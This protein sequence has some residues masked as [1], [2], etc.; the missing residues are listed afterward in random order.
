MQHTPASNEKGGGPQR[1]PLFLLWPGL[2]SCCGRVSVRVVTGSLFVLWLWFCGWLSVARALWLV[3]CGRGF[4]TGVLWLGFC[5]WGFVA[6]SLWLD[7]VPQGSTD[8][9]R[10]GLTPDL[11]AWR[12]SPTVLLTR[13]SD[14]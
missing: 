13:R 8:A 14:G 9:A 6:G 11:G 7:L 12:R 2:C 1:L 10:G 5:G 4:V 3:L